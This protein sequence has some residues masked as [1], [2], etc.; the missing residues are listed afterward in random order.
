MASLVATSLYLFQYKKA[1]IET[2]KCKQENLAI[3]NFE[4]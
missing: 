3:L 2:S 1:E 4:T